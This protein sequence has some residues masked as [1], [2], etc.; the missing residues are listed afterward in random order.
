[1]TAH[2]RKWLTDIGDMFWLLPGLMVLAGILLA[3]ALVHEDKSFAIPDALLGGQLLYEPRSEALLRA[4]LQ[5]SGA[6]PS[7]T[8]TEAFSS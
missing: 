6:T 3:I 7:S 5:L 2:L 1:M 4:A 8:S